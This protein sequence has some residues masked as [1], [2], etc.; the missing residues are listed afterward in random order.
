MLK[1]EGELCA[2]T[3]GSALGVTPMAARLQLYALEEEGLVAARSEPQGRGRPLKYWSLTDASAQIFPDA[4]QALAVEMINSV[5]ELFGAEGLKKFIKRHG[6]MQRAAYGDKLDSAKTLGER[7]KRLAKARSD[8][9]YMA[10]AKRDGRDWLLVENHCPICSA[11]K[12]C[13]GLC[14]GELQVFSDVLGDNVSV[15]REEHILAGARRCAY[16]VKPG[17]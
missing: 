15:E 8:E 7:V 5:E 6:D 10:E 3:I 13:T 9:G 11:A 1:R 17:Q 4:H 16:R 12:A 2:S 14:A